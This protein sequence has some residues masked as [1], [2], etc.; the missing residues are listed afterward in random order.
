[1]L[2]LNNVTHRRRLLAHQEQVTHGNNKSS[3]L[4]FCKVNQQVEFLR[5]MLNVA[6]NMNL[7]TF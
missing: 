2:T 7:N 4:D 3:N 5:Q 1:M 6:G